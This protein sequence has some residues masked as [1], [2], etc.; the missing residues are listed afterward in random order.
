V[1]KS[2]SLNPSIAVGLPA[3]RQ[4]PFVQ[5]RKRPESWRRSCDRWSLGDNWTPKEVDPKFI[6]SLSGRSPVR[7]CA[8]VEAELTGQRRAARAE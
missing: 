7:S 6:P 8:L 5:N 4:L 3:K 1:S 2:V